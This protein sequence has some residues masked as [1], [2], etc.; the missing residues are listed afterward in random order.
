MRIGV[1][2][3]TGRGE[4]D[5]LLS[6]AAAGL[7]RDGIRTAGLVRDESYHCS[8][9]NGCD[10]MVRVLPDG[11]VI[12]ITQDLGPGSD[13][14]RLD[15]SAIVRAVAEVEARGLAG[16]GLFILNKFG[17]EEAAGRG[18]RSVIARALEQGIPVLIGVGP[19][20]RA[21]FDRFTAGL[22]EPLPPDTEAIALWC[23]RTLANADGR[24]LA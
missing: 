13:A 5:R 3:V 6:E 15:P 11:P 2:S 7:A 12:R 16:V 1:V 17:P 24:T 19:A 8:A 22:A 4:I 18:F 14:C 23:R 20:S 9:A 10:M 21:E